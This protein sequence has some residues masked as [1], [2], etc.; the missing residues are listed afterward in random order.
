MVE[1]TWQGPKSPRRRGKDAV[2]G[3]NDAKRPAQASNI[4]PTASLPKYIDCEH[5]NQLDQPG[6]QACRHSFRRLHRNR[7]QLPESLRDV[8]DSHSEANHRAQTKSMHLLVA[9]QSAAKRELATMCK[10]RQD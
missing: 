2:K 7:D 10:A 6:R 9:A 8:L 3:P 5:F 4:A 1:G